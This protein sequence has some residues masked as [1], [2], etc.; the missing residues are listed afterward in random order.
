MSRATNAGSGKPCIL[1]TGSSGHL[2][3]AMVLRCKDA[4]IDCVGIDILPSQTTTEVGSIHDR[5]FVEGV[6]QR[7]QI[8][9][10]VHAATL[11]KPHVATHTKQNFI[12]VNVSGTLAL[13]ECGVKHSVSAFVFISTTSVYSE[14]IKSATGNGA[15]VD[16]LLINEST[17]PLAK[18]IYGVTK[19]SAEALASL[20]VRLERLPVVVLRVSRFF[21]ESDDDE[22]KRAAFV[23][24][25]LKVLEYLYRRVDVDDICSAVML[26]LE[27][28]PGLCEQNQFTTA[29][30][31]VISS[32]SPLVAA[33]GDGGLDSQLAQVLT[34]EDYQFV[35]NVF[36]DE[37]WRWP[38]KLDRVYD[39]RRAVA[40]L[41]WRARHDF[42]WAV[43]Y[44]A[45]QRAQNPNGN[46][47]GIIGSDLA[48]RVG[49]R[50]YHPNVTY[51]GPP[52]AIGQPFP[53]T[54][55]GH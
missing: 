54:A 35:Q 38:E 49:R 41:G 10:V 6:F 7:Y 8:T 48:K 36:R 2:G 16:A 24:A 50:S 18:N 37:G 19:L 45:A 3:A 14:T 12:D 52:D 5:A 33:G 11:H 32:P 31:Y 23:D 25:N 17:P 46:D 22:K 27:K 34:A 44:V 40:E 29:P 9:G 15:V 47:F 30:T 43:R 28:A 39:S 1:V 21:H 42:V 20:I 4:L 13:L 53:V 26:T 51:E 55:P